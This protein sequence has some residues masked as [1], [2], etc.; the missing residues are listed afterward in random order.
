M[1]FA[2]SSFI[3]LRARMI[4]FM[5]AGKTI[6][7]LSYADKIYP[8]NTASP[9]G[10]IKHQNKKYIKKTGYLVKIVV[11]LEFVFCIAPK[12]IRVNYSKIKIIND[13]GRVGAYCLYDQKIQIATWTTG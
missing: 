11:P 1:L 4:R 7:D 8:E 13:H 6:F 2:E 10:K 3:F 12:L 5:P 9:T